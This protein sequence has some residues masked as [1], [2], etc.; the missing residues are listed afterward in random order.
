MLGTVPYTW[1]ECDK[2]QL[3]LFL[4][5]S[6]VTRNSLRNGKQEFNYGALAEPTLGEKLI[7]LIV[8]AWVIVTGLPFTLFLIHHFNDYT[9]EIEKNNKNELQDMVKQLPQTVWVCRYKKVPLSWRG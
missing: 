9:Q 5:Q 8:E 6:L 4:L 7:Q 1:Q 2:C 3:L